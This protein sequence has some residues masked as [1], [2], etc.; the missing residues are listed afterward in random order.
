MA[1]SR[2]Y[3]DALDLL[4]E[5]HAEVDQL[6]RRLESR[7]GDR[8][9]A[10][11][12]LADKLTAHTTIEEKLFYPCILSEETSKFL[13]ESIE[14]HLGI[15]RVL[16]DMLTLNLDA[17]EFDARISVLK[18]QV[19]HHAHEEEE[20]RLFP[21]VRRAMTANEL[22]LIGNE[23]RVMFEHLMAADP[24]KLVPDGT[25]GALLRA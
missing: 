4:T 20:A 8:R 2:D 19:L 12:E 3:I 16:S 9:A 23:L 10:I 11:V 13:H 24:R 14:E 6:L 21:A 17:D 1:G 7:R 22:A 18:K 15:K 25:A 5:Q